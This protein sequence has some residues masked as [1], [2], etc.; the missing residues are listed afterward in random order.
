MIYS[1]TILMGLFYTF[2][3][4]T[5]NSLWFIY[6]EFI[7]LI[8]ILLCC[9]SGFL[10][11]KKSKFAIF[12]VFAYGFLMVMFFLFTISVYNPALGIK[13]DLDYLKVASV[14]EMCILTYAV[15]Y[16]IK[17]LEI[18][19]LTVEMDLHQTGKKL[20]FLKKGYSKG[21]ISV[22]E[23]KLI[24]YSNHYN[25]TKQEVKVLV[26]LLKQGATN[27]EIAEQLFISVSTVKF[28]LTNIYAK[29][30]VTKRGDL[31]V[32]YASF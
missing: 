18:D 23:Q 9:L 10:V 25:L 21:K 12:I 29:L 32:S 14:F 28:H 3:F 24:E 4:F 11:L 31:L 2:Y 17:L 1:I 26:M 5:N 7:G 13:A 22:N 20:N 16:R 15:S 30:G 19:K 27:K 8:V 6:G